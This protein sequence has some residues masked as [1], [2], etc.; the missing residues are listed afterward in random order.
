[1]GWE[2]PCEGTPDRSGLTPSVG[3]A[4]RRDGMTALMIAATNCDRTI[5]AALL[6][7]GADVD[8]QDSGGCAFRVAILCGGRRWPMVTP[9]Q[10]CPPRPQVDSAAPCG[11]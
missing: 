3:P 8:T 2:Y 6:G 1:M 10:P 4:V 7:A 9:M 11:G 5:V